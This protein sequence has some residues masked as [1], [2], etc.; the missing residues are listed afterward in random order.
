M[1]MQT[2]GSPFLSEFL[3]QS[4]R[5]VET[6]AREYRMASCLESFQAAW[7]RLGIPEESPARR[8]QTDPRLAKTIL[9]AFAITDSI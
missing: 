8:K 4:Q 2:L 1:A 9:Q 6:G 3:L 5:D 7:A